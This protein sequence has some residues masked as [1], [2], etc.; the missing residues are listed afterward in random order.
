[1]QLSPVAKPPSLSPDASAVAREVYRR[2][3]ARGMTKKRLAIDSGL[4]PTYVH[5][6][7][8]GKSKNPLSEHLA[9]LAGALGCSVDDLGHPVGS[10]GEP[11]INQKVDPASILPLFPDDVALIRLWRVLPKRAKDL[12]LMRITELLPKHLRPGKDDG[13]Q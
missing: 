3:L 2:M 6:L 1:M 7:F 13:P 8:R 4:A 12:V 5:D 10:S 11:E 9:K